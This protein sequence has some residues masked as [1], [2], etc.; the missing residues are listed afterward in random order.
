MDR[1]AVDLDLE[2]VGF[3][4]TASA[5]LAGHE[6]VGQE[7]HLHLHMAGAFTGLAAAAR[8]VEG[9][10]GCGVAALPSERLLGEQLAHF[11]EG[12]DVGD[13]VRPG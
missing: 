3:E 10:G 11:I 7:H 1:V 8:E 12:L 2:H 6:H 5:H 13:R 9:K 4:A